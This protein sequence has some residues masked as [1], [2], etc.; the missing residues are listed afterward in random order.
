MRLLPFSI[1]ESRCLKS[2]LDIETLL[3][4]GFYPRIYDNDL[5][6]S[7]ALGDY[8]E[9]YVERDVR[10]LS[11]IRN[12][13]GFQRFVRLCAGR[14][15]QLL[16]LHRLGNDAGISHTTARHDFQGLDLF[17]IDERHGTPRVNLEMNL[18]RGRE[19]SHAQSSRASRDVVESHAKIELNFVRS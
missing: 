17:D 3:Y 1:E 12:L 2:D 8:F 7:Q 19:T 14:V 9:T 10:Q 6:P 15:G 13:S 5:D 11:E 18:E 16:N 4:T